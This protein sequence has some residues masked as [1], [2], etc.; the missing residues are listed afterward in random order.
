MT[1]V[2]RQV[3][4]LIQVIFTGDFRSPFCLDKCS[5]PLICASTKFQFICT[6]SSKK[7]RAQCQ[8]PYEL[9]T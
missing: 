8:P 5:F 9:T 7:N 1:L 2:K 4:V 6:S 3:K